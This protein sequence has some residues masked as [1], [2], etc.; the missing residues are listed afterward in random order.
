MHEFDP[1][2]PRHREVNIPSVFEAYNLRQLE[3]AQLIL[4]RL[5]GLTFGLTLLTIDAILAAGEW[6]QQ[7]PEEAP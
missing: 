4:Q 5:R 6:L 1:Q 3:I 2:M 7:H